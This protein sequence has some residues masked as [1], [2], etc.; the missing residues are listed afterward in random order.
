[1]I[2]PLET[3]DNFD[4]RPS[5]EDFNSDYLRIKTP[6]E[7]N[8]QDSIVE[9]EEDEFGSPIKISTLLDNFGS[10][11]GPVDP[12]DTRVPK[13]EMSPATFKVYNGT[14]LDFIKTS[15]ISIDKPPQE[16][17][18]SKY[19]M[20]LGAKGKSGPTIRA[21]YSHLN[22]FFKMLYNQN[23]QQ[24][25]KVFRIVEKFYNNKT[26]KFTKDEM[27]RF[28]MTA[29]SRHWLVRKVILIL[30]YCGKRR[31]PEYREVTKNSVIP[32][33]NG[34][35]VNFT[36][37]NQNINFLIPNGPSELG[38]DLASIIQEYV[39]AMNVDLDTHWVRSGPFL[40]CG[41]NSKSSVNEVLKLVNTP[42]GVNYLRDVG[43]DVA[44]FLKLENYERYLSLCFNADMEEEMETD[45]ITE[46]IQNYIA[47][48]DQENSNSEVSK[49]PMKTEI[50]QSEDTNEFDEDGPIEQSTNIRIDPYDTS[51]LEKV[52]AKKSYAVYRA[53][54]IK[55]VKT[56]KISIDQPPQ[57]NDFLEY[58]LSLAEGGLGGSSIKGAYSHL[59]KFYRMLYRQ[60]GLEQWPQLFKLV[61]CFRSNSSK[62][63]RSK[64]FTKEEMQIFLEADHSGSR[65]WLLR[66]VV[67]ILAYCGGT[68]LA[69]LRNITQNSVHQSPEGFR[70]TF[71]ANTQSRKPFKTLKNME[72]VTD[73]LIPFGPS[74]LGVDFGSIIE[75][76]V[77]ALK[78]IGTRPYPTSPF[79]YCGK[80][81]EQMNDSK[82]INSPLGENAL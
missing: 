54:W 3:E 65:Y 23:L 10:Q 73:F 11:S 61:E 32:C 42:V 79:L 37:K 81:G 34:F 39:D 26:L 24:W 41:R 15:K 74:D 55:F 51:K 75:E 63:S 50:A 18:F 44:K 58:L 64:K 66:K 27:K 31:L 14:W 53:S 22:K 25:P 78:E 38:V 33:A 16:S 30:G 20:N 47:N 7:L 82:F 6:G 9:P 45:V 40:H 49:T 1:M 67:L 36:A 76:Y 72:K 17:D 60:G 2:S 43:K 70:V 28:L 5:E 12:Y 21:M 56:R 52:M 59:N 8:T 4:D 19:L 69:A 35:K 13:A 29:D 77:L 57:E 71:N 48:A 62:V 46:E 68:R 80:D